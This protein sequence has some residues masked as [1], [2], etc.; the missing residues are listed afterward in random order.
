[1]NGVGARVWESLSLYESTDLVKQLYSSARH[2]RCCCHGPRRSVGLIYCC[3]TAATGLKGCRR[4][5]RFTCKRKGD[6][7]G[8]NPRPSEPQSADTCFQVLPDVA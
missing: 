3:P 8:S 5:L 6:R 2:G 7:R 1:M 4:G